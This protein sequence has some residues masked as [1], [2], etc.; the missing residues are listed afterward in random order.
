MKGKDDR[1]SEQLVTE[2]TEAGEGSRGV[3]E[4]ER[5]RLGPLAERGGGDRRKA[6]GVA[7]NSLADQC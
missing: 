2:R 3:Q 7:V 5:G 1:S 6:R 4:V